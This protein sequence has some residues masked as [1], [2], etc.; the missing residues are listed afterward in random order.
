MKIKKGLAHR[1][2]DWRSVV[3]GKERKGKNGNCSK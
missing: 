1:S 3:K 2:S